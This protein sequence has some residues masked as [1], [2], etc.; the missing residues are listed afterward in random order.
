MPLSE[1]EQ[2]LL[3]EMERSLYQND[4]DFVATVSRSRGRPNY[5]LLVGRC[6]RSRWPGVATLII[7]VV[8]R[9]PLVGVL[10]FARD[11]RVAPCSRSRPAAEEL[12]RPPRLPTGGPRRP[13]KP[14]V[15]HPSWTAST[16]AGTAART[17]ASSTALFRRRGPAVRAGPFCALSNEPWAAPHFPPRT[18]RFSG[19]HGTS[20]AA[21]IL[22]LVVESGVKWETPDPGR[23][24]GGGCR[25]PRYPFP[26][27]RRQR[28]GSSSRPSSAMSSPPA[29]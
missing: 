19:Q 27:A 2:R 14:A 20:R 25:V 4:A 15:R 24:E 16:S 8:M 10:G 9:Q 23:S 1:Q 17:V 12:P 29:W 11:V 18:C 26:Q 22:G 21:K 7:G 13:V 3:E 5:T 6:A 28:G